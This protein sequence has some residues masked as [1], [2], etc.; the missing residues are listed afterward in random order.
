MLRS[1]LT[2]GLLTATP[3]FAQ[4]ASQEERFFEAIKA[5]EA[6]TYTFYVSVDPRFGSLLAPV[7]E[8]PVFRDSQRCVLA[9]IEDEG[10]SDELEEYIAA[11]E[12]QGETEI[13]SLIDLADGL[14]EVMTSDLIFAASS[15]CG[16]MSYMTKQ[17][18]T[19][20]FRELMDDPVIM[21]GLMGE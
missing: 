13:T 8:D 1:L 10:G 5:M 11:M 2:L 15:E 19:P 7:A 20:E 6:R 17:M 9:R 16:A 3:A 18:V 21:Q 12:V 14:P 4:S